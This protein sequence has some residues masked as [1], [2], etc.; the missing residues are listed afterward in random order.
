MRPSA[1]CPGEGPWMVKAQVPVGGR[2]K[3]GGVARCQLP[4]DVAAAVQRMLGSRLKGYQVDACL[5]EQTAAG[6]EHYL[7]IM[8]DAAG[9]GLRVIYSAQGGV[10]IEQS[11]SAQGRLCP[12]HRRRGSRGAGRTDR[13]RARGVAR[14]CC[15]GRPQ[16]GGYADRTRACAGRDQSAFR[17]AGSA[18]S[19][20]MP[21]WWWI[22]APSSASPASQR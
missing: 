3:A 18:A 10:D 21:S 19:P 1:T 14:S 2:G 22:S 9:Y 12:P 8:V 15:R 20:G 7:A 6:E 5:I 17:I 11:G 4:Q 13:K 16:V